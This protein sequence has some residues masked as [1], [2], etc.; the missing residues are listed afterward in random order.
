MKKSLLIVA[1]AIAGSSFAQTS[2]HRV[3]ITFG[4]GSQKYSGDLGNGFTL[5]NEVWRGGVALNVNVYLNPSFDISGYG[6]IG[7]LGYCQPHDKRD[8][9]VPE[10]DRC[11]AC[12]TL[13]LGNLS[14][15][16]YV[17][18]VQLRYKFN[19][20]YLLRENLR[21]KPYVYIGVAVNKLTD[22]MK[23][24]CVEAGNYLTVNSG[25]GARYYVSERLNIGYNLNV[26]YFTSDK[27]DFLSRGASDLYLQNTV[28]VGVDLF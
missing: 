1:L 24:N 26:G 19:N 25:I 3:G 4:G 22:R 13:G 6:T 17:T 8:M 10:E 18:G 14:S 20:G 5:K 12:L 16:M 15:R 2:Q 9:I 7:D 21:I 23:M 27:L 11:P 28:F